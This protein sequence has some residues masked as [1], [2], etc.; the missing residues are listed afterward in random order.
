MYCGISH[1]PSFFVVFFMM[2][3]SCHTH[4]NA[5]NLGVSTR[6]FS[7][8]RAIIFLSLRITLQNLT[9]AYVCGI[10]NVLIALFSSLIELSARRK[11]EFYDP[12]TKQ[13]K[14]LANLRMYRSKYKTKLP[15]RIVNKGHLC[16]Q[17]D[18]NYHHRQDPYGDDQGEPQHIYFSLNRH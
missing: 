5:S 10:Y 13:Y 12:S 3:R 6:F 4:K 17:K 11:H 16:A 18:S 14:S 1:R 7:F 15:P 9:Y 2:F 8:I